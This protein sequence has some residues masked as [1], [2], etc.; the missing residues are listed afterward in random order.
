MAF[1]SLPHQCQE[2]LPCSRINQPVLRTGS[3]GSTTASASGEE[4]HTQAAR[5]RPV[6]GVSSRAAPRLSLQVDD[7]FILLPWRSGAATKRRAGFTLVELLIV[8]AIIAVLI[9]LVLPAVQKVREAANRVQC[10][11]H[12]KQIGLALLHYHDVQHTF[13]HAYDARALFQ[14]P[15]RTPETPHS[16]RFIVTKSWAT[17][18]LPYI[19][20]DNLEQAGY[21]VYHD[22]HLAL[23]TCPS[24]RRANGYYS[25]DKEYGPQALTD[26]LAVTG[27]MTFIGDPDA[28]PVRPK[29]NGVMYESSRTRLADITDGTSRTVVVGERP[30]S[31]DLYW[32]WWTWSALD[33]S[34]GVRNTWTVY[35]GLESTPSRLCAS[36]VP[37]TYR[38]ADGSN[39]D[40]HHFWSAHPGG[41]NWLFADGSVRFLSYQDNAVLPALATRCGGEVVSDD[42]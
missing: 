14:D 41:G 34:L 38:P 22:Q 2:R 28:G 18:I 3:G 42:S 31:R 16:R 32:G 37:E 12:L 5:C 19:E 11:H 1:T 39:C 26:Y 17:L 33:A 20:Q 23:Y 13:P 9:A 24:D 15:S 8:V 36:Q 6:Y 4:H 7:G 40:V 10:A 30:P 21:A 29:C 25:G 35:G 27:T